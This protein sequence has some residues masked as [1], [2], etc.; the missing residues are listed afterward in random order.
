MGLF[1]HFPYTNFHELNLAWFLDT[2]HDLLKEWEEQKRE[3]AD[4]KEAWQELKDFVE[5]YFDNL[6]LQEEVNNKLEDMLESGE[7]QQIIALFFADPV[8][9]KM[10]GAVGD[11][12]ADDTVAIQAALD[13]GKNVYFNRGTYK[14]GTLY[15]RQNNIEIDGGDALIQF[16]KVTGFYLEDGVHDVTFRNINS[17]LTYIKD[18]LET[19]NVHIGIAGITSGV[20]DVYNITVEKCH[21]KG[22]VMGFAASSAKNI[23]ITGSDFEQFVYKPEDLAGGYGILLQSCIDVL[24]DGC[25]FNPGYYGRHDIYVSVDQSKTD[26]NKLCRNVLIS[27]CY[28]THENLVSDGY[29]NYYSPNTVPINVRHSDGVII[30]G[31]GFY[32]TVGAAAFYPQDGEI[33]NA[34]VQG[35]SITAP[36]FKSTPAECKY[37]INVIGATYDNHIMISD[38]NAT[39]LPADYTM[40]A[41]FG[42]TTGAMMNCDMG[43][44]RVIVGADCYMDFNNLVTDLHYYVIRFENSNET[45]GRCRGVIWRDGRTGDPFYFASGASVEDGFSEMENYWYY[46]INNPEGQNYLYRPALVERRGDV[47]SLQIM[48]LQNLPHLTPTWIFTLPEN[49]RPRKDVYCIC[50]SGDETATAVQIHIKPD[51]EVYAINYSNVTDDVVNIMNRFTYVACQFDEV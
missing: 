3:F 47:G 39:D 38:V 48:Q 36:V 23:K 7:L 25:S 8:T 19:T 34:V 27:N 24:I 42:K 9:P 15:V 32:K 40:F 41:S 29:G 45:K 33:R 49:Y 11:G 17:E 51:G 44:S 1:E 6:N 18:S 13:S 30:T 10:Y 43:A 26:T 22:G 50:P 46:D 16:G 31:C 21:F 37:I 28:F 14:S 12:V 2:F 35:C 4:I 5:Y 20:Y